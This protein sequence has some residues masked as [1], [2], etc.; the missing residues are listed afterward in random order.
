[1]DIKKLKDSISIQYPTIIEKLITILKYKCESPIFNLDW[2]KT[3][4]L[5]S[6]LNDISSIIENYG[7]NGLKNLQIINEKGTTPALIFSIDSTDPDESYTILFYGHIDK[8]PFG[9]IKEWKHDPNNPQVVDS[10]LYGRGASNGPYSIFMLLMCLKAIQEQIEYNKKNNNKNNKK[11]NDDIKIPKIF[12]ILDSSKESRSIDL[13]YYIHNYINKYIKT[14]GPDIVYCLESSCPTENYFHFITSMKSHLDFDLKIQ[15]LTRSIHSGNFG[16][17][18]PD[19]FMIYRN[20]MERIETFND[21]KI[22]YP[23]WL[24]DTISKEQHERA[25]N[26]VDK[27]GDFY[28]NLPV[29]EGLSLLGDSTLDKYI[30]NIFNPC[31]NIVFQDGLNSM[32]NASG[33][34]SAYNNFRISIKV[35][36]TLDLGNIHEKVEELLLNEPPFNASIKFDNIE[37]IQGMN[38]NINEKIINSLN[39]CSSDII[40][41]DIILYGLSDG[42]PFI[43]IFTQNYPNSNFVCSGCADSFNSNNY[44]V[45]ENLNVEIFKNLTMQMALFFTDFSSYKK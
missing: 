24:Y 42:V 27:L 28:D 40:E 2:E 18:V 44:T 19:P 4:E 11:L 9:D 38:I 6:C 3:G 34:I 14:E 23:D 8:I 10:K 39:K 35:P 37:S 29:Y 13:N 12:C 32:A 1:M 26:V 7:I 45:D 43:N 33:A 21:E 41:K 15:T 16:G 30:N 20:L 36:P 5:F 17:L 31:I 22:T 25:E